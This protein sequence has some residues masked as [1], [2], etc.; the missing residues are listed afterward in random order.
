MVKEVV[1]FRNGCKLIDLVTGGAKGVY[2]Y[3]S[4]R[5]LNI[6]GDKS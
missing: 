6:C 2:G 1:H 5:I 3:P 4:G